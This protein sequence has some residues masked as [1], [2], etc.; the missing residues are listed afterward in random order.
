M[1]CQAVIFDLDG[2]LLDTL[3]DIADS[4]NR[5]L[6]ARGL[7]GHAID[8][9][10]TFVGDGSAVL[11]ARALPEDQRRPEIIDS[12]LQGFLD[13]YHR[14]WDRATRPYDGILDLLVQ[15][16]D[17]QIKMAVVTNKPHRFTASMMAR[18][19]G[20][21]HIHPVLGQQDGIPKKPDPHQALAAAAQMGVAPSACFFVGD[22]AIDIQ[23]AR[24]AAMQPI[25]A[26]WGFRT[27]A[28][29]LD[30]G[31]LTVLGHPLELLDW[32]KP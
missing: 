6:A 9:F 11:V 24:S 7:T 1:K 12:C 25:G 29:L 30:A 22:S 10:R 2:T 14:N 19:F 4:V 13:D 28:E 3:Q 16:Q 17:R 32:L 31:A 20:Q 23:T 26:G 27:A 5:V 8:A 15:L 21:F 18:Y